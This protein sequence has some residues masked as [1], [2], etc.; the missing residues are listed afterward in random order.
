MNTDDQYLLDRYGPA[1]GR[2]W[3]IVAALIAII[4]IPWLLWS[5]EYHSRPD[6]GYEIISF[7]ILSEREV[8]LTYVV[9]RN[10]QELSLIC[11]LVARDFEKNIVGEVSDILATNR[12]PGKTTRKILIPT[13]SPAVN[14][15]VVACNS[16]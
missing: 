5:A 7:E 12:A 1:R 3:K 9:E 14:G 13:R 10:K 6:F 4:M 16:R 8:S 15:A 2:W 11:T